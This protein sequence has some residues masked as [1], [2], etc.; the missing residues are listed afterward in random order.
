MKNYIKALIAVILI[1]IFSMFVVYFDKESNGVHLTRVEREWI[2]N[3]KS[4]EI[5]AKCVPENGIYYT[6]KNGRSFGIFKDLQN[7]INNLYG[8][9]LVT[10][11][12]PQNADVLWALEIDNIEDKTYMPTNQH[13][14]DNVNLYT[15]K[16]ISSLSD[17]KDRKIAI[18]KSFNHIKSEYEKDFN[19]IVVDDV[20]EIKKL[21]QQDEIFGFIISSSALKYLNIPVEKPV[22]SKDI[23]KQAKLQLLAYVK[24]DEVLKGLIEK[25]LDSISKCKM[26]EIKTKNQLEYIKYN[27]NL[28]EEEKEWLRKNKTIE[29]KVKYKFKPYYYENILHKKTGILNAY[30]KK[31]E[32]ILGITF[33]Q[34]EDKESQIYFGANKL[35]KESDNLEIMKPYNSYNLS[36]YSTH[37][38]IIDSINQLEGSKIGVIKKID[39]EYLDSKII[40]G[41][42]QL[43]DNYDDMVEAMENGEIDYFLCDNLIMQH[44]I[45]E[46]NI[47][48]YIFNV[49]MVNNVFYE[50]IGVNK[51]NKILIGIMKKLDNSINTDVLPKYNKNNIKSIEDINYAL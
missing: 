7:Y 31:I 27:L 30:I 14:F 3:N 42:I 32:Y 15:S 35:D 34:N 12:D 8:I 10:K 6:E 23:C 24:E 2:K 17:V 11:K 22:Y 1:C 16:E 46:K 21:Y 36:I 37:E 4:R 13:D 41:K 44:Y 19:F 26:H 25:G 18:H 40:S 47:N 50:S 38:M 29:M 39:K 51:D 49:G 43:Y 45:K 28:T 48:E 20:K 33:T 5:V 9:N